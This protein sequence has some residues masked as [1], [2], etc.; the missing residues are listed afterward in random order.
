MKKIK[1]LTEWPKRRVSRRLGHYRVVSGGT[2]VAGGGCGG[3]YAVLGVLG[4]LGNFDV[5]VVVVDFVVVVAVGGVVLRM[6]WR[7]LAVTYV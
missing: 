1:K 3:C 4:V 6:R 2:G 7:S 5:V